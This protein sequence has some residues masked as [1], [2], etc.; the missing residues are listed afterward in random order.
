MEVMGSRTV[1]YYANLYGHNDVFINAGLTDIY[2]STA[3][4]NN[5]GY[6]GLYV[7]KT[8]PPS[9]QPNSFGEFEVEQH[10]PWDWWDN[11]SYDSIF[12]S[13]YG[14][15]IGYGAANSILANPNMSASKGRTYIDTIQGYLNPRIYIALNLGGTTS[16]SINNALDFSTKIYPNPAN[17]KLTIENNNF[18]ISSIEL[19]DISGKS[20]VVKR[21]DEMTTILD[22]SNLYNG[23]YFVK[24]NS[25]QSSIIKKLIVD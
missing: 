3:N 4:I 20:I 19:F 11:V 5:S 10:A 18:I 17:N 2:T 6:E 12:T 9:N 13:F 7:F 16:I 23:I 14:T 15:S 1:Q 22:I 25:N 24:V 21:V 8:T